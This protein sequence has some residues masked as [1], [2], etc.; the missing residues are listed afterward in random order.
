M[1]LQA[2]DLNS[3]TLIDEGYW[4]S[5][6]FI[7]MPNNH[8][9]Q[10]LYL[11]EHPYAKRFEEIRYRSNETA[12]EAAKSCNEFAERISDVE[13]LFTISP[14]LSELIDNVELSLTEMIEFWNDINE[15]F[16]TVMNPKIEYKEK[17]VLL[18]KL[19]DTQSEKSEK[20]LSKFAECII[21]LLNYLK[22]ELDENQA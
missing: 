4:K 11:K 18:N 21:A 22:T 14:T 20:K 12:L 8:E 19:K 7:H 3:I 6:Y 1:I 13:F 9:D 2:C 10:I 15:S 17:E 5:V 16:N